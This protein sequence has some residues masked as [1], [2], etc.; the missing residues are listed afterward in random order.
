MSIQKNGSE[1]IILEDKVPV[2]SWNGT[3]EAPNMKHTF[4]SDKEVNRKTSRLR[5]KRNARQ[6]KK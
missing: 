2:T 5:N 6:R 3:T 1:A 4:E